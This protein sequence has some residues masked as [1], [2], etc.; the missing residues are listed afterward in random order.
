MGLPFHDVESSIM[1]FLQAKQA[2]GQPL[3][4]VRI[5][6]PSYQWPT[7]DQ[8]HWC[9]PNV[10]ESRTGYERQG[11]GNGSLNILIYYRLTSNKPY[12]RG[13]LAELFS[14]VLK[15]QTI[16]VKDYESGVGT[17]SLGTIRFLRGTVGQVPEPEDGLYLGNFVIPFQVTGGT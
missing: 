13:R 5:N 6:Y 7:Q 14:S 9:V 10:E 4:N 2:A 16:T 12:E 8:E 3:E 1:R 11:Q 15:E 17:N